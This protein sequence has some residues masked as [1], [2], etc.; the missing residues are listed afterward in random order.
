MLKTRLYLAT[1]FAVAVMAFSGLAAAS[2]TPPESSL[3]SFRVTSLHQWVVDR[4][5]SWSPPGITYVK[6]AKETA[7]E[8]KSRY[9]DI[10][11]SIISVTYDPSEKPIFQGKVGRAM[12]TALLTSIA[13][14]ESAFR[15][16]VD[17][18]VGSLARGDSGRSWCMAQIQLGVPAVPGGNTRM[19]VVLTDGG[20]RFIG[21][22][23][24]PEYGTAWGGRD[25]VQDR[26]K[27]FRV[28]LRLARLSFGACKSL[29][30]QD[31]LSMYT[32]GSC[33]AG[34]EAS[35]RRVGQAM[36]WLWK[37]APPLV[38][39]KVLDLLYPPSPEPSRGE[40]ASFSLGVPGGIVPS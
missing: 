40:G 5:V 34:G 31:R 6:D 24:D 37:S 10:A 11:N 27:C 13:F 26:T 33:E 7:E 38:D 35:R 36:R 12:T 18:G 15:K 2:G 25:L 14:H 30:V 22:P 17:S 20:L 4:M 32:S 21:N 29:P 9:E 39:E 3:P 23:S 16:D 8:G 19:R 1:L 28:A